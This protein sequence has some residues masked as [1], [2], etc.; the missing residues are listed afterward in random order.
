VVTATYTIRVATPSFSPGPTTYYST[1]NVTITCTTPGA[2]IRYTIDGS[3]P[4]ATSPVYTE[5]IVVDKTT[6]IRAYATKSGMDDSHVVTATYTIRVATPS[7][8]PGPTT[9]YSTQNVTITCTTPG[10]TIRYTIDGSIPTAT[11]PVYTEPIVVDKTTTI[12]AYATKSGIDDSYVVTATYTIKVATP[13]FSL[14]YYGINY[15]T[16][17]NLEINCTTPGATIRYTTDG[18]NPTATSP[19]Y[20]GPITVDKT[21]TIKAYA[22]KNGIDDSTVATVTYSFRVA[23]P[24]FNPGATTYY[25]TQNITITCTTPEAT[26][27]YTTDGSTPTA[28]SPVYTG[29]IVV[30][31]TTTIKAYATKSGIDDSYM[32]TA[33]YIIKVAAPTFSPSY[34]GV[35]YDTPQ[36]IEINTT[37]PGVTI[38]YTV[39]G[40]TPITTSPV[41]TGPIMVDKTTT[42]KAYAVKDGLDDSYV[43]TATYTIKVA[44]PNFIPGGGVYTST[45]NVKL[46]CP[47]VDAVIRYTTDGSIPNASSPEYTGP[48]TVDKTTTIRAYAT[49]IGLSDSNVAT[50]TY[51]VRVA[52][53]TF[54]PVAGTYTSAQSVTISCAMSGAIIRY[55]TDG[56]IPTSTSLEYTGPIIVNKTTMIRAYASKPGCIDSGMATGT[57]TLLL[58]N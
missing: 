17:Q 13:S 3:I 5:P 34:Y 33:T 51:T 37:T 21:T 30:D 55:T 25:S 58:N 42:I 26:I 38:F 49:K 4:T 29:P 23:T 31:K 56:S 27:R 7:F 40:S 14:P 46:Y 36:N 32:A 9:Y 2:T 8:S 22:T 53:P 43:V 19:V 6:T 11:S 24:R 18:S 54:N 28:T 15:D 39:D 50:A 20:T 48:I 16:P 10:A 52:A 35:V 41:Y 1:Q 12:R 57:Y 45:Q 47:T 44:M